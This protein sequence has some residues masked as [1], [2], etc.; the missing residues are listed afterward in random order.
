MKEPV[1]ITQ[2]IKDYYLNQLI[3][4]TQYLNDMKLV[5]C[6]YGSQNNLMDYLDPY[7]NESDA[8]FITIKYNLNESVNGLDSV[9]SYAL[10]LEDTAELVYDAFASNL[11]KVILNNRVVKYEWSNS[12]TDFVHASA[13]D[14]LFYKEKYLFATTDIQVA[15]YTVNH[16]FVIEMSDEKISPF[17]KIV[18]NEIV[19]TTTELP[20]YLWETLQAPMGKINFPLKEFNNITNL[21]TYFDI[22]VT[23]YSLEEFSDFFDISWSWLI[24]RYYNDYQ[25]GL[26]EAQKAAIVSTL[27]V[28]PKDYYDYIGIFDTDYFFIKQSGFVLLALAPLSWVIFVAVGMIG[29]GWGF[30]MPNIQAWL[31]LY[32]PAKIRGRVVGIFVL[33]LYLGQFL[34]PIIALPIKGSDLDISRLFLIGGIINFVLIVVPIALLSVNAIR[35]KNSAIKPNEV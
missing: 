31:L 1:A 23:D 24:N 13:K 27:K 11:P 35:N 30:F 12:I 19:E 3:S 32:T 6:N 25:K 9:T 16:N 8:K 4:Y 20:T 26:E 34:S 33:M 17:Y 21:G 15:K 5:N 7:F 18:D 28:S 14:E 22:E 2:S 10:Y 29:L